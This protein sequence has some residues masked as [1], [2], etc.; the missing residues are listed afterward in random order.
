MVEDFKKVL[1]EVEQEKLSL[2]DMIKFGLINGMR[3]NDD[4]QA[5]AE[6]VLKEEAEA[7]KSESAESK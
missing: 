7:A 4:G 5:A 6:K 1:V 2:A 3:L